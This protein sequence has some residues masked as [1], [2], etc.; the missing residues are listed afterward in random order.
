MTLTPLGQNTHDEWMKTSII[1]LDMN[2]M[3]VAFVVMPNHVHR[4]ICIS[5]TVNAPKTVD[6]PNLGASTDAKKNWSPGSLGVIINQ[7]KRIC[8]IHARKI[9]PQFAWQPRFYDIIIKNEKSLHNIRRYIKMNPAKWQRDRNKQN[10]L[11]F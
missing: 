8:T 5:K 1:R 7:Y 3:L 9:N 4:I 6:A 2:L 10:G 11:F